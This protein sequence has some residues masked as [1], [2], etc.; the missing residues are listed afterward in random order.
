MRL[1]LSR[2]VPHSVLFS[3][4]PSPSQVQRFSNYASFIDLTTYSLRSVSILIPLTLLPFRVGTAF[5][6]VS[7][8]KNQ[9][10]NYQLQNGGVL[11]D[12]ASSSMAGTRVSGFREAL[13]GNQERAKSFARSAVS[14]DHVAA[15]PIAAP[16]PFHHFPAPIRPRGCIHSLTTHARRDGHRHHRQAHGARFI[17]AQLQGLQVSSPSPPPFSC[18]PSRTGRSSSR[19]PCLAQQGHSPPV[20]RSRARVPALRGRAERRR[21]GR[22][23]RSA[24]TRPTAGPRA[25]SPAPSRRADAAGGS[26]P[27][28]RPFDGAILVTRILVTRILVTRIVAGIECYLAAPAS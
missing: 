13:V 2:A 25:S 5:A 12:V 10:R 4:G 6:Y 16:R 20:L 14:G 28:S 18:V 26:G 23:T 8:V 9:G 24:S 21:A 7:G 27:R 1:R 17:Q 11:T 19:V 22:R 3:E 15:A